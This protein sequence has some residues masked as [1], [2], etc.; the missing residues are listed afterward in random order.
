MSDEY[1][2]FR[3]YMASRAVRGTH[4]PQRV[5]NLVIRSHATRHGLPFKLSLVEYAMPGSYMM[6]RTL[7]DELPRLDGIII[8][9][10]FMLPQRS[11]VRADVYAGVLGA[12]VQLH[13]ALEDVIIR[14]STDVPLF[15]DTLAVAAALRSAPMRGRYTK[16]GGLSDPGDPFLKAITTALSAT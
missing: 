14:Y 7:L 15:E 12:G 9:S 5:Q 2:G 8:F 13:A 10:M 3:G 4:F 1:G 6:L 16:T 11:A